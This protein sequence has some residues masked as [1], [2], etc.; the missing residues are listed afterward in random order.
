M[1]RRERQNEGGSESI[2]ENM[3]RRPGP[4]EA[5]TRPVSLRCLFISLYPSSLLRSVARVDAPS[6]LRC[7]PRAVVAS[8]KLKYDY[9]SVATTLSCTPC[10]RALAQR[11][12]SERP[13][14]LLVHFGTRVCRYRADCRIEAIFPS[15]PPEFVKLKRHCRLRIR[16]RS[17]GKCVYTPDETGERKRVG[18]K[19]A[20]TPKKKKTRRRVEVQESRGRFVAGRRWSEKEG[21][22][23]LEEGK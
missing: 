21:I 10:I 18:A 3:R 4:S 14:T 1:W 5:R 16:P 17:A 22:G 23:V 7:D 15:A 6:R 9:D 11:R 13:R 2:S 19:G 20:E 12:E 8:T